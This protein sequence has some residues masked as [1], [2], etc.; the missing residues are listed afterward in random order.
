ML[1]LLAVIAF[2]LEVFATAEKT[3]DEYRY[4]FYWGFLPV[5]LLEIDLS[6]Y[7]S[8]GV[9]ISSGQ[10]TGL[11][12]VL[13]RY[14]AS[15]MVK[16]SLEGSERYYELLGLDRG[17]KEVRKIIFDGAGFPHITDFKDSVATAS[18]IADKNYDV[19]S[20]D[21]LTAFAWFFK[22]EFLL[23]GCAK[24]FKIFDG[25]KRF[26]I[27]IEPLNDLDPVMAARMRNESEGQDQD[28]TN[29]NGSITNNENFSELLTFSCRLLMVGES[30]ESSG[31]GEKGVEPINFWPFNKR[32]QIIDVLVV[33]KDPETLFIQ[34][35][36][37]H[38]PI[39][40][41]I[42]RLEEID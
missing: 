1:L 6:E 22:E 12:R 29:I 38:S 27:K 20:V 40:K 19:G 21:P 37:I 18:L 25:K 28:L 26:L 16:E 30:L 7:T 10:T 2:S 23:E 15:V 5:G 24:T 35:I 32:D 31:P 39:G 42:G 36:Y 11:S 13:K 41:I 4:R 34:N 33:S 9:I 3:E 17:E 8:K 14:S